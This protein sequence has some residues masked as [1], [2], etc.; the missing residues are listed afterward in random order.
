[1]STGAIDYA[2]RRA[3]KYIRNSKESLEAFPDI[4]VRRDLLELIDYFSSRDY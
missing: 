4:Q 3:E 1:V 2:K